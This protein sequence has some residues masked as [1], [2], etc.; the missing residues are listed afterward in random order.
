MSKQHLRTSNEYNRQLSMQHRHL[1]LPPLSCVG[2]SEDFGS[3]GSSPNLQRI[4]QGEHQGKQLEDLGTCVKQNFVAWDP[5]RSP[6]LK[7][8]AGEQSNPRRSYHPWW[9][10]PCLW[11]CGAPSQAWGG[12]GWRGGGGGKGRRPPVAT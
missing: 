12:G 6:E 3:K 9:S 5:G 10:R 8:F 2:V 4:R 7:S 1:F 11:R